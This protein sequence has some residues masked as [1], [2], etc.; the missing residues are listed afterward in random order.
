[1]DRSGTRL[2]DMGRIVP[3]PD[4]TGFNLWHAAHRP[5]DYFALLALVHIVVV[6]AMG[7]R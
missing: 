4:Q 2:N 7:Y 5:F 6:P 3:L 1:M